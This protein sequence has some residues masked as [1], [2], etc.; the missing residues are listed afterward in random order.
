MQRSPAAQSAV[1]VQ[2]SPE[3]PAGDGSLTTGTSGD[4]PAL[5]AGAWGAVAGAGL[6]GDGLGA[7]G[8]AAARAATSMTPAMI[9]TE[10]F[11]L[12]SLTLGSESAPW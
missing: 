7:G 11:T 1:F 5:G 2:D 6:P 3:A 12:G 4:K 10:R 8:S 9:Q